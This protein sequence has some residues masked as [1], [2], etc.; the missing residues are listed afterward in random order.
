MK[1]ELGGRVYSNIIDES[2]VY[3]VLLLLLI[4]LLLLI[5]LFLLILARRGLIHI[6]RLGTDVL[7]PQRA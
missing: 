1:R 4:I 6:H 7:V 3:M 5:L 2:W